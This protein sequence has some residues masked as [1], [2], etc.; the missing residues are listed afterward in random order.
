MS[1]LDHRCWRWR[2]HAR[3]GRLHRDGTPNWYVVETPGGRRSC[4]CCI[5]NMYS[6]LGQIKSLAAGQW[7]FSTQGLMDSYVQS[8]FY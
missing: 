5:E 3:A 2:G 8:G 1:S 7:S 6:T 4:W